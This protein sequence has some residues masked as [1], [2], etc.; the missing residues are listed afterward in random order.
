[1]EELSI[2]ANYCLSISSSLIVV[3][4]HVTKV[5][6]TWI[7]VHIPKIGIFPN[8]ISSVIKAILL[9]KERSNFKFLLLERFSY[10][11]KKPM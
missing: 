5:N 8:L 6:G 3:P 10:I 2:L 11:Q 9:L 1:M 4:G 7:H